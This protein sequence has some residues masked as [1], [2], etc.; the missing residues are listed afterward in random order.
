M[1]TEHKQNA[2]LAEMIEDG[3]KHQHR[4]CTAQDG[5]RLSS[6]QWVDDATDSS[7]HDGL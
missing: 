3:L 4:P 7:G 5:Q 1:N 2:L 6:K